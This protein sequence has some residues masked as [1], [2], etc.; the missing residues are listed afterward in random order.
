MIVRFNNLNPTSTSDNVK[1][2]Y[3]CIGFHSRIE[4]LKKRLV[5]QPCSI[6][7]IKNLHRLHTTLLKFTS[8]FASKYSTRVTNTHAHVHINMYKN[9]NFGG[10]ELASS[11]RYIIT[12]HAY[13][14]FDD[15]RVH[16]ARG[17]GTVYGRRIFIYVKSVYAVVRTALRIS[18]VHRSADRTTNKYGYAGA[19]TS[20]NAKTIMGTL[21]NPFA[22]ATTGIVTDYNIGLGRTYRRGEQQR[23]Q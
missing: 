21:H 7:D 18:A 12:Y 5:F 15:E 22:R 10:N 9:R 19:R 4:Q 6:Y 11:S 14:M 16:G 3:N 8:H 13:F 1:I 17:C 23:T 20:D 2:Q